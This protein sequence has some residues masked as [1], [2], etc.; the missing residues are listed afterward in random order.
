MTKSDK[1]KADVLVDYFQSVYIHESANVT[2]PPLPPRIN[3]NMDNLEI[4]VDSVL[5]IYL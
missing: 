4:T 2:L 3:P 5:K 1:E